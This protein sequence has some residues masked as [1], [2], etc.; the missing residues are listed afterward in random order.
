[1]TSG[2]GSS[3]RSAEQ[4]AEPLTAP[5][6]IEPDKD[7]E[8]RK[9]K[10]G[11]EPLPKPV[12]TIEH[13]T[14]DS[15]VS[16]PD[17]LEEHS[18]LETVPEQT[19]DPSIATETP[20]AARKNP[21]L[22]ATKSS[23][24]SSSSQKL[25]AT[26]MA[27]R[28]VWVKKNGGAATLVVVRED[29]LVDE[30]KD[31]ILRKYGNSLGRSFDAPDITLRI[32]PRD[33][34]EERILSPDESLARALDNAFPGG[35]SLEEALLIHVP[36]K[37]TPRQS[38]GGSHLHHHHAPAAYTTYYHY[39][40]QRPHENGTDYFP[41]MPATIPSPGNTVQ[42]LRQSHVASERSIAVLNTGQLPPL[43]SPGGSRRSHLSRQIRPGH[44]GR[45][46]TAS[47]TT[48]TSSVASRGGPARPRGDSSASIDKLAPAN[49][50]GAGMPTPPI[51][52]GTSGGSSSIG[53]K[54]SPN[55]TMPT[56][57]VSSPRPGKMRKS[58]TKVEKDAGPLVTPIAPSLVDTAVPPINVLIVEDNMIN[59][60]LLEQFVRRLK[61]HWA[62]AVNGR[63]AVQ[64]WRQ[65]GFHLVL[66]DI[67]LP[68]MSGLEATRE[69]R[70]LE[71][72]N[73]IG[74]LSSSASSAAPNASSIDS[75]LSPLDTGEAT[76][77][78]RLGDAGRLFKSPVI[79]VALTASNLQSD[80]HEALAAG[81]NDF[82]TKVSIL[83]YFP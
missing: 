8:H 45:Q 26:T 41:Q 25:P 79:I 5:S 37:R 9:P 34:P 4:L 70:R 47:P 63:E 59:M 54:P 16:Q 68:I 10:P 38:P 52:E 44:S 39:D 14:P 69:I 48:L 13:P 78:D 74:V 73:H 61:V 75:T 65:G 80:R 40:E 30:A 1:V 43:S 76:E 33:H 42:D 19:S 2:G 50:T 46:H 7:T 6:S 66:M 55:L 32:T 49:L 28:K 67:Q 21:S 82:L 17:P 11:P 51:L 58:R 71:R 20:A 57:R 60:K 62:T 64:K 29:D 77:E 24:A 81:C 15:I 12:L 72:I 18:F 83:S 56:P 3:T 36:Q 23:I 31:T 22:A 53:A 27:T 35:Q